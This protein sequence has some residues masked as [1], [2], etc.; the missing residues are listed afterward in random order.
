M[1]IKPCTLNFEMTSEEMLNI[2]MQ[3]NDTCDDNHPLGNAMYSVYQDMRNTCADAPYVS[4]TVEMFEYDEENVEL[5]QSNINGFS[6][7]SQGLI[8][9]YES[10]LKEH[11]SDEENEQF[12]EMVSQIQEVMESNNGAYLNIDVQDILIDQS[13]R[14]ILLNEIISDGCER[15]AEEGTD[16]VADEISEEISEHLDMYKKDMDIF[17][18][19]MQKYFEELRQKSNQLKTMI[20]YEIEML[21]EKNVTPSVLVYPN[22]RLQEL[23]EGH[24]NK[25]QIISAATTD[26]FVRKIQALEKSEPKLDFDDKEVLFEY[27]GEDELKMAIKRFQM[28]FPQYKSLLTYKDESE[29][30]KL[31]KRITIEFTSEPKLENDSSTLGY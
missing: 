13:E 26:I 29:A 15:Y 27:G 17:G 28:D 22:N 20:K 21:S 5:L 24:K 2:P 30:K 11:L 1:S 14:I 6:H 31:G 10:N 12:S 19:N 8:S 23:L 3:P 16:E 18:D 4:G 9:Y 25:E 7:W